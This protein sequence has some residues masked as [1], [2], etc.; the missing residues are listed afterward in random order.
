VIDVAEINRELVR[1]D[2]TLRA[3]LT[4][5]AAEV[6]D[7]RLRVIADLSGRASPRSTSG[8]ATSS[9]SC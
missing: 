6:D 1:Q 4:A 3:T 8:R 9:C 2:E 5:L 7:E